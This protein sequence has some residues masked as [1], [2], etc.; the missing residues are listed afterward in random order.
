MLPK[1]KVL[2]FNEWITLVSLH[3]EALLKI[4]HE[5]FR[6]FTEG[7]GETYDQASLELCRQIGDLQ[8][9]SREHRAE[10]QEEMAETTPTEGHQRL[11]KRAGAAVRSGLVGWY[12]N[13]NLEGY[14]SQVVDLKIQLGRRALSAIEDRPMI[15]GDRHKALCR[16]ASRIGRDADRKW[17]EIQARS[18]SGDKSTMAPALL[19]VMTSFF[20]LAGKLGMRPLYYKM[21]GYDEEGEKVRLKKEYTERE[22]IDLDTLLKPGSDPADSS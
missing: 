6:A 1:N 14:K 2:L 15:E 5:V 18:Q 4:G 11:H 9:R 8:T 7:R 13:R 19:R 22:S 10:L 16:Y 17:T 12:I 21:L 20:H 3:E